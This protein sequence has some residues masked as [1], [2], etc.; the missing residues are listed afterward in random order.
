[1]I[2]LKFL[3]VIVAPRAFAR[4]SL[5]LIVVMNTLKSV[6]FE[7]V[8]FCSS[9]SAFCCA[10]S[11]AFS[12][13]SVYDFQASA[14]KLLINTPRLMGSFVLKMRS[15]IAHVSQIV[16]S[17]IDSI[18]EFQG[19]SVGNGLILADVSL[20]VVVVEGHL[21]VPSRYPYAPL[22]LAAVLMSLLHDGQLVPSNLSLSANIGIEPEDVVMVIV[23]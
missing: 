23:F 14:A 11:N 10:M 13:I 6:L 17:S 16:H 2:I 1:M 21:M 22:A 4:D 19:M 3:S 20:V 7:Y 5:F 15:P 18:L 8:M 9:C 12:Y